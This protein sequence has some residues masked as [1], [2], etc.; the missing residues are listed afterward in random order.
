MTAD[1]LYFAQHGIAVNKNDDPERPLATDGISQTK[2]IAKQLRQSDIP[3]SAIFHSDKLRAQQTADIFSSILNPASVSELKYLSPN[4]DPTLIG[5]SFTINNALYIGHLPNLEKIV[6]SLVTG[7]A[8]SNIIK[9][10]NSAVIGLEKSGSHYQIDS[11][12][13]PKLICD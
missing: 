1:K 13:T 6:S 12:L 3:I 7:D 2:A 4:S 8:E 11:Y 9:F 5:Q 10:Q